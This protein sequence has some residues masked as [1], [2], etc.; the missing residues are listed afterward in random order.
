[1]KPRFLHHLFKLGPA[2][3]SEARLLADAELDEELYTRVRDSRLESLVRRA[4]QKVPFYR[5]RFDRER[6]E[7]FRIVKDLG[8][9]PLLS[10]RDI[11]EG[12]ARFMAVDAD[13]KQVL[14]FRTSGSTGE[15]LEVWKSQDRLYY[16]DLVTKRI[17]ARLGVESSFRPFR[18]GLVQ[19]IETNAPKSQYMPLLGFARSLRFGL[20]PPAWNDPRAPL[21]FLSEL[22]PFVLASSPGMLL[23]LH[24]H[25]LEHDP[26]RRYS[27][28]PSFVVSSGAPLHEGARATLESFL[29]CPIV[30][31]FVTVEMDFIAM[32]CP[33][34]DGFHVDGLS[35]VVE[36][37]RPDGSPAEEGEVGELVVTNLHELWFPLIRYRL[38][39]MGCI[40]GTGCSCGSVFPKLAGLVTRGN[41]TFLKADGNRVVPA[42][43]SHAFMGLQVHQYQV[44]QLDIDSFVF[45][46]IPR[47]GT[48]ESAIAHQARSAFEENFGAGVQLDCRAMSRLS[49]A[50][51]KVVPYISSLP[52]PQP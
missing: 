24:Q 52:L 18:T 32:E 11:Q 13:L 16:Y 8:T 1:M 47:D 23:N 40:L 44:E 30:D 3:R 49:E 48:D 26:D 46:Y 9:L 12:R 42:Y 21:E 29:G 4:S 41:V 14:P 34:G 25:C 35:K 31:C 45:R 5:E 38:G 39:D 28:A 50:G 51:E 20:G 36:C 33:A 10:R 2:L 7:E 15:P 43:L 6:V 27:I 22:S 37:L 19:L 17:M